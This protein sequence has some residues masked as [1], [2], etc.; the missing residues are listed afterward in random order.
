[1]DH[2]GSRKLECRMSPVTFFDKPGK[3]IGASTE[4][5]HC[6]VNHSASWSPPTDLLL[7]IPCRAGQTWPSL[8]WSEQNGLLAEC[9]LGR[10]IVLLSRGFSPRNENLSCLALLEIHRTIYHE[11]IEEWYGTVRYAIIIN[12]ARASFPNKASNLVLTIP[13]GFRFLTSAKLK[14]WYKRRAAVLAWAK[15]RNH[16]FSTLFE[17]P[18]FNI[19]LH[20]CIFSSSTCS[21]QD[22]NYSC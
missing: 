11:L 14:L 8:F 16:F 17:D 18:R 6:F 22:S 2:K 1:M 20:I 7:P 21:A 15:F 10:S 4:E 13:T 5:N 12:C 9:P 19:H 3:S